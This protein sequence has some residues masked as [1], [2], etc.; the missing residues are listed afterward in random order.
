MTTLADVRA[1]LM[2][3]QNCHPNAVQTLIGEALEAIDLIALV[4]S[5]S[6]YCESCQRVGMANCSDFVN[7]GQAKCVTCHRSIDLL[8]KAATKGDL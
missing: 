7:C 4:S 5:P 6:A 8:H 2:A 1:K 3:A